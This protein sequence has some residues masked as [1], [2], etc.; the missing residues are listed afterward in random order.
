MS[1]SEANG[2]DANVKRRLDRII[3]DAGRHLEPGGRLVF[4][5]FGFLGLKAARAKLEAAGLEPAVIASETQTFPRIGYERLEHIR[6][7]DAESTLP[8]IGLP[9]TVE[10]HVVQGVK[11][12][13]A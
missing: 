8:R 6:S 9:A 4:T 5:L 2:H 1:G 12:I 10:R 3:A 7:L 13:G 11:R